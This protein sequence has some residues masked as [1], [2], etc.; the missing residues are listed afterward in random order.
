MLLKN[1]RGHRNI[2]SVESNIRI[3]TVFRILFFSNIYRP[4]SQEFIKISH[5]YMPIQK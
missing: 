2:K 1:D 4:P 5:S 3:K